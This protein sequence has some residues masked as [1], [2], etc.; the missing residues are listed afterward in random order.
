[1]SQCRWKSIV[2]WICESGEEQSACWKK[3]SDFHTKAFSAFIQRNHQKKSRKKDYLL[4]ESGDSR[5]ASGDKGGGE[6]ENKPGDDEEWRGEEDQGGN[7]N[8]VWLRGALEDTGVDIGEGLAR[9]MRSGLNLALRWSTCGIKLP[10]GGVF[11]T[12]GG[13]VTSIPTG[14]DQTGQLGDLHTHSVYL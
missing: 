14:V 10:T 13:G 1:M 4:S 3:R 12:T 6:G 11:G 5:A 7:L 9:C 2:R 8:G